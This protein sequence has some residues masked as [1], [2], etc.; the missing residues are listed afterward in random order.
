[1][2]LLCIV[3]TKS[4]PFHLTGGEHVSSSRLHGN[5]AMSSIEIEALLREKVRLKC[6]SLKQVS[7]II[8]LTSRKYFY[9]RMGV[10]V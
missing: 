4:C 5:A 7:S 2:F 6:D 9:R 3:H 10:E 8:S 1:M